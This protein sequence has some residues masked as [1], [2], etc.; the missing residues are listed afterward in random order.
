VVRT[1]LGAAAVTLEQ[2]K[3]WNNLYLKTAQRTVRTTFSPPTMIHALHGNFGLP[4]DWDAALPPSVPAKAWHLWEIR[5]HHPE[6]R[7]LTG[8]ATWFN[9]QIETLPPDPCRILAG[10]SLGGRL[11]FHVLLDRPALWHRALIISA[12]PGLTTEAERT[13]RRALDATW[14]DRCRNCPWPEVLAAWN[15]QPILQSPQGPASNLASDDWAKDIAEAFDGWSLGQQ[16]Y[17]VPTLASLP[18]SGL[19]MVG[20]KDAKF[21]DLAKS[22]MP[23]LAGF[24]LRLNAGGGHRFLPLHAALVLA[25]LEELL[26]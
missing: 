4:S 3:P 6:A 15:A 20:T 1:L 16:Q 14:K 8:F 24:K 21:T 25:T 12:H 22:T 26:V 13:A 9:N 11:A 2:F 19:W 17:L 10:Y 18:C 23:S 5:R 7:T